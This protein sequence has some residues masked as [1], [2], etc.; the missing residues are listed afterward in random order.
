MTWDKLISCL[1]GSLISAKMVQLLL[2]ISLGKWFYFYPC[3]N[4]LVSNFLRSLSQFHTLKHRLDTWVVHALREKCVPLAIPSKNLSKSGQVVNQQMLLTHVP[5]ILIPR[6]APLDCVRNRPGIRANCKGKGRRGSSLKTRLGR[7]SIIEESLFTATV[8]LFL[9][10]LAWAV[11][12]L[13]TSPLLQL[14]QFAPCRGIWYSTATAL[15]QVL[16]IC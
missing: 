14:S 13:A 16:W 11:K 6:K 3:W 15:V 7:L 9:C 8:S 4:S 10:C 12:S 5:C 2:R 1:L